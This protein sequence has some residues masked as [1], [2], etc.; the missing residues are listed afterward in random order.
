MFLLSIL[1]LRNQNGANRKANNFLSLFFFA[2]FILF[3]DDLLFNSGLYQ[4]Y[5]FLFGI[6]IAAF[7]LLSPSL[8]LAVVF[9]I[10]PR[11]KFKWMDSLHF[12]IFVL[13]ILSNIPFYFADKQSKLLAVENQVVG[14]DEILSVFFIFF[15]LQTLIYG[16]IMIQKLSKHRK[17][18]LKYSAQ[19]PAIELKWLN[20]LVIT[21]LCMITGYLLFGQNELHFS[22]WPIH[23]FFLIAVLILA[24]LS[25]FQVEVFSLDKKER[26]EIGA[27]LDMDF[28]G[29]SPLDNLLLEP[30]KTTSNIQ[31]E[32]NQDVV[33]VPESVD[34]SHK[35][36]HKG[37]LDNTERLLISPEREAELMTLIE[38]QMREEKRYLDNEL[39]VLRLANS[40]AAQAYL[41]SHV[42]NK[43]KQMNFSTYINTQRVNHAK[44][45]LENE[46]FDHLN[47]IQIAYESGFNSKTAF[48]TRFKKIV[49]CSPTTYRKQSKTP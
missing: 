26:E 44:R 41:V 5:P 4:L 12:L 48:N 14:D 13:F 20:Y 1:T 38:T 8:F 3:F 7:F 24:R 35:K 39:N 19:G 23:L 37:K 28:E 29:G 11:K 22:S 36:E 21:F 18:I 33:Q 15:L 47:I 49:G 9:F 43:K 40:V 2:V 27:F 42:I 6:P 46:A 34:R 32:T 16:V 31:K 25:I 30:L 17:N 10:D 45:L